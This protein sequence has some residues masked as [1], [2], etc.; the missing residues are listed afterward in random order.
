MEVVRVCI[1][2]TDLGGKNFQLF[3]IQ[4]DAEYTAEYEEGPVPA[5]AEIHSPKTEA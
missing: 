5:P 2:V 3:T 1:L 4:Y